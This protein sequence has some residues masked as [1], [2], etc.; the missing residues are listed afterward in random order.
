MADNT[1]L[2]Q[3]IIV[4]VRL[5]IDSPNLEDSVMLETFFFFGPVFIV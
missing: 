4:I 2:S 5:Q 3:I 1:S